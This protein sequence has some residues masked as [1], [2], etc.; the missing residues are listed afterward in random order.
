MGP[1]S[2]PER[3]FFV[4]VSVPVLFAV[5]EDERSLREVER[6]LVDRYSRSY[7]VVCVS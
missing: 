2:Q 3:Y 5:D 1:A 6:E 4:V 7:R